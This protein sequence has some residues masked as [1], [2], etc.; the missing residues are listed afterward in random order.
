MEEQLN[1]EFFRMFDD[2]EDM[3]Y[4]Q[5]EIVKNQPVRDSY[6]YAF[7]SADSF[8]MDELTFT[9]TGMKLWTEAD[10]TFWL[11]RQFNRHSPLFIEMAQH[12]E[13]LIGQLGSF[14]ITREVMEQRGLQILVPD[15]LTISRLRQMTAF[16]FRK[17][18]KSYLED[19]GKFCFH[20]EILDL[21]MRYTALDKRL[22]ATNEKIRLI[23][24]GKLTVNVAADPAKPKVQSSAPEP[25][26]DKTPK[27]L[28]SNAA[29]LP[30][31]KAAVRD[32][33]KAADR[34]FESEPL[35]PAETVPETETG[36]AAA[37]IHPDGPEFS[38]APSTA[39]RKTEDP[40][41]S[42]EELSPDL[43][44]NSEMLNDYFEDFR[45][46]STLP[47]EYSSA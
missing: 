38:D 21:S 33:E 32:M 1:Q 14:L 35:I 2:I 36:S 43:I 4:D 30:V 20:G 27:P 25:E 9:E 19:L 7:E 18:F 13:K 16:V 40:E 37:P 12:L 39:F 42:P 3:R 29:A 23:R 5:Q 41:E 24:E 28:P 46:F 15:T 44:E 22:Y 11:I 26:E 17:S 31:D 45:E 6:G 10:E 8:S 47:W 34:T